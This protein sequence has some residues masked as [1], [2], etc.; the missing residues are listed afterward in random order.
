M[1]AELDTTWTRKRSCAFSGERANRIARNS[2][3]SMDVMA[4]A[5]DISR[6]RSYTDTYGITIAKTGEI[7]NQRQSGRCWMFSAFNVL[8][9]ETMRFLD[10]DTFEFS[11]A[12]GMF[13][14]KLE[15]ANATLE[16]I[17]DTADLPTDSREVEDL[18]E[19]GL[20]DGGYYPF[21]MNIV[22]KWG[23]V[24]KDAM[25]ETAC[26][27]NSA[28]MDCQLNR[29]LRRAA[30][31]LRSEA[32]GGVGTDDLR[33]R[34]QELLADVHQILCICLGEPPARFDL[35]LK[36]GKD[37]KADPKKLFPIEPAPQAKGQGQGGG[38]GSD[39]ATGT[40]DKDEKPSQILRDLGLTPLEFVERYVPT[41]PTAY[42]SLVY[43]PS[44]RFPYG[45]VYRLLR[46]DSFIA[47]MRT[48]FLNV[49][50]ELLDQAAIASLKD[51]RP[52]AMACD[53]MQNFPRHIEDFKYVLSTDAVDVDGLFG[54]DLSMSRTDM[55]DLHETSLTH[56]MTFQGV[57]LDGNG[58][59]KAWR[60]ENSWGKDAGKDGYLIMSADWFH[61]YGGEID[62]RREYVST[63]LLDSWDDES[64]DIE[65][66]PWSSMGR[67]LGAGRRD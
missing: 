22:R 47:G 33:A 66:E 25:G 30:G 8:R 26:S 9:Q 48:R 13:Y 37:C 53:V 15:K 67:A 36:V 34:K 62:V 11:Q 17:I 21:A 63:E 40:K 56:A 51:G 39:A 45:R 65:V 50:P 59:P 28:Q 7:T 38:T 46:T 61:L 41:D 44:E 42:V 31:I 49:E 52:L 55:L 18:L 16:R 43:I 32:Q 27:K 6:M 2:V 14:D 29:A 10:V 4:A 24:P 54:I 64:K 20:D 1:T 12:F 58:S 23:L 5:R 35:E 3:T 57:E 19:N 60:V